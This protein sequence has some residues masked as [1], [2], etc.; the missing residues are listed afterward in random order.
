MLEEIFLEATQTII[1]TFVSMISLLT[2]VGLIWV[3]RRQ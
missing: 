3:R 1:N 2:V